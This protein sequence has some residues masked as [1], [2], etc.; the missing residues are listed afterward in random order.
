MLASMASRSGSAR[1]RVVHWFRNDLRLRDNT[2]LSRA[3]GRAGALAL[4]F[5]LDDRILG[6]DGVG[7]PRLRFLLA[8]L[9]RLGA[10]LAARGQRLVVRRG[11]PARVVPAV[12][13]ELAA[14]RV[15]WNR[16]DGPYARRR[17]AAVRAAA[18][19][20]GVVVETARDRVIHAADEVRTRTGDAFR[21]YTPYRNAWWARWAREPQPPGGLPRLP[22]PVPGFEGPPLPRPGELGAGDDA[23]ALPTPGEDAA[24]RRLD[25][26]LEDPVV[27]Y[28]EDRDRPDLDGT[29]RLSPWLHLGALSPRQCFARALEAA[30]VSPR[31]RRGVQR[32][33]DELIWREFYSAILA[34]HPRV[35][36]H[37]FRP[38]FDAL[39]WEDDE[40][41][42][43]AWCAGRTGVPFVDAGMRQLRATGWMHNRARMVVASYLTKDLL[44]DWRRGERYFQQRLLDGDLASNNGGW[45]WVA[46]S[47]T[48]A[49]PWF[50]IFNPV[51]QGER[52]DPAG[53]YVRRFVPELRDVPA[54]YVHRPWEAPRPPANY[55]RP[56]V[57]HGARRAEALR[58]LAAVARP[59]ER[60]RPGPGRRGG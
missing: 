43:R 18:E 41:G 32:W 12:L 29:S 6:G 51:A 26:F 22:A 34:E 57:D 37:A 45:Q 13:R 31:R 35:V 39:R 5:V 19:A 1:E 40:A 16:D 54:A 23:T 3:A 38:A 59:R 36:R 55:P 8:S 4:L 28:A 24:L 49:Q 17:D 52:Y 14:D 9:E 44:V 30:R 20:S 2:A 47:G 56:L 50:R 42:F 10:D 25:R 46:A 27:R 15:T 53:A 11:D 21:V 60:A 48:D 33:L 58:R 7:P